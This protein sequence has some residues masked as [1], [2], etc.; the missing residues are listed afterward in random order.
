MK[1]LLLLSGGIDSPV[2]GY[3]MKRKLDIVPVYFDNSP[4]AGEDTKKRTMDVARKLG[5]KTIWIV[6][7]GKSLSAFA[8]KCET[9]YMCL[10]C[11]RMMYRVAERLAKKLKASVLI[12]GESLA[13]VASQ[14]SWNLFVLDDAVSIPVIRPLIGF[15]K[16]DAIKISREAGLFDTSTRPV[17]CCSAV[18]SKPSTRADLKK[19]KAE[20]KKVNIRKL[21]NDSLKKAEEIEC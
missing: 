17:T 8:K 10:F 19:I 3:L 12:T 6:P 1:A 18:P 2:A 21:V 4:Y 5:F 7:H 11:K 9:R 14:T 16:N 15:D 20:E 13:Q